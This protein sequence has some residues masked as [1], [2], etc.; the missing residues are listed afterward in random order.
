MNVSEPHSTDLGFDI[1]ERPFKVL[2]AGGFCISDRVD[3]MSEIFTE[4][5]LMRASSP[6]DF[7]NLVR[8][9]VAHPEER[10]K[11]VAAGQAK[12]LAAHTYHHR[13]AQMLKEFGL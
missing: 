7:A 10:Q 1:I 2:A 13:V 3:E 4:S 9:Y 11:F 8:Y 5:E 6:K 12:V